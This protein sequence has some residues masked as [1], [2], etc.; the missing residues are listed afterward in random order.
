MGKRYS[1]LKDKYV[2]FINNQKMFFV[3]TSGKEGKVNLSP[4]G[5]DSFRVLNESRV[6]WLNLTG[7]GN[8][9]SAHVQE[10]G[11]M[12]I[13]FCAFEG[14]PLILRLYGIAKVVHPQ[15]KEWDE[16]KNLFPE[17]AG[18]RQFFEMHIDLVQSSCGMGVPLYDFVD[19]REMLEPYWGKRGPEKIKEYWKEKNEISIDGKPIKM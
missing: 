16:L 7:S 14:K 1:E 8:E 11:R 4:K 18:I 10:N 13:M 3:A 9:T 17:I 12:T 15:D 2:D 6:V 5:A 19:Q